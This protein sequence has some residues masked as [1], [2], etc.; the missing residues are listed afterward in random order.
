MTLLSLADIRDVIIIASGA[1]AIL[2]LIALFVFTVVVGLALRVLLGTVRALLGEE[3]TPL[4][5]STRQTV[6]RVQGTAAFVT[7]TAVSP[8]IRV[9]GVVAGGRRFIAV[10]SGITNRRKRQG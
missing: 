10:V 7:E 9:Y 2:L 1:I 3:V 6:K 5:Q 4:V 8:V